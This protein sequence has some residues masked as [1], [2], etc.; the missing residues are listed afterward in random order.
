[1]LR[2]P[3]PTRTRTLNPIRRYRLV[4]E[5]HVRHLFIVPIVAALV[6]CSSES[7]TENCSVRD[8]GDGTSTISCPDGTTSTVT[9]S[10]K[11]D[12]Q[13]DAE[14]IGDSLI[15]NSH[16]SREE[17]GMDLAPH[18]EAAPEDVQEDRRLD[19]APDDETALE[20]V[21]EDSRLDESVDTE[22]DAIS[23]AADDSPDTAEVDSTDLADVGDEVD[24]SMDTTD[25][26]LLGVCETHAT[27]CVRLTWPTAAANPS[28]HDSDQDVDLHVVSGHTG[29]GGL[30]DCHWLSPKPEWGEV[31]PTNDGQFVEVG[32]REEVCYTDEPA[33]GFYTVAVLHLEDHDWGPTFPQ[34]AVFLNGNE[35]ATFRF[36]RSD[37]SEGLEEGKA[38]M[39][40]TI[41]ITDT[42]DPSFEATAN[43]DDAY[44]RDGLPD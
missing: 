33:P 44:L 3:H 22:T 19:S 36:T 13:D 20:D 40:G 31:G 37:S 9:N 25:G 39:V 14:E 10:S 27:F 5:N 15:D 29:Y 6:A 7:T 17:T 12:A 11:A 34:I 38:W 2:R 24:D 35:R 21:G 42:D 23:D 43:D 18:D 41:D 32:I 26:D 30:T 1:M 4:K 8:N 16:D 28:P